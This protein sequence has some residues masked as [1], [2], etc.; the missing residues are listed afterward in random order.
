[1]RRRASV[2]ITAPR[3][4]PWLVVLALL[5]A[6]ASSV[7]PEG[8]AATDWAR[9]GEAAGAMGEPDAASREVEACAALGTP[10]DYAAFRAGYQRG[11]ARYCT[12]DGVLDAAMAG[13]GDVG[14]CAAPTALMIEAYALGKEHARA[15]RDRREAAQMTGTWGL[16]AAPL[17]TRTMGSDTTERRI[18]ALRR[19][20]AEAESDRTPAETR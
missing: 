12:F 5:P 16:D 8:C 1:M 7:T 18:E 17:D 19:R 14:R 11:L 6:C 2:R 3:S 15:A 10:P 4:A 9:I 20:A 13:Q